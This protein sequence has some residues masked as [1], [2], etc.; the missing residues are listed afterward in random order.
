MA[1]SDEIA[2]FLDRDGVVNVKAPEGDYIKTPAELVVLPR[3]PEAVR[4]LNDASIPVFVVTNQRGVARGLMTSEA[5][6]EIHELLRR[7]LSDKGAR[8]DGIRTCIH[9]YD[10]ACDCRKPRPGMLLGLAAGRK[11]D[12]ARSWMIGDRA[13]DIEAGRSAGCRTIL[14][15]PLIEDRDYVAATKPEFLAADLHE[16]VGILLS[17]LH[18]EDAIEE[19]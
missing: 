15:G 1:S 11:I 6:E 3:V 10:D 8:L 16:A 5:L 17:A 9:G 13:S 18:H 7:E 4:R 14:V 2:V 12:M 19:D